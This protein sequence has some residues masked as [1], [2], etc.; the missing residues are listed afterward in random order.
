MAQ[1]LAALAAYPYLSGA[2]IYGILVPLINHHGLDDAA[3]NRGLGKWHL[4]RLLRLQVSL[5]E[6][7]RTAGKHG[8]LVISSRIFNLTCPF[9]QS[10]SF[11]RRQPQLLLDTYH[12]PGQAKSAALSGPVL[13]FVYGGAWNSG[14]R[15]MYSKVALFGQNVGFDVVVLD[16]TLYPHEQTAEGQLEDVLEGIEW[17]FAHQEVTTMMIAGHSAGAHLASL[18]YLAGKRRGSSWLDRVT[19]LLLLS[20]VYDIER[21]YEWEAG[22][23]VEAISC[24]GRFLEPWRA[25]SPRHQ[26]TDQGLSLHDAPRTVVV[27]GDDD[28]V[29]PETQSF[30]LVDSW[31]AAGHRSISFLQIGGDHFQTVREL[32]LETSVAQE[33]YW[34]TLKLPRATS[35][36]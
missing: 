30:D 10:H 24:M 21:H 8:R 16:Y 7:V 18:A 4:Q 12:R 25:N 26:P 32:M 2:V 35:R 5:W 13:F 17:V 22:R 27:H 23:G 20:G 1:A 15:A 19:G 34:N 33:M 29:V 36:L 31:R 14:D 11:G 3:H 9:R 28:E 6:L